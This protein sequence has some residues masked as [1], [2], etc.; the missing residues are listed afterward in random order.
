MNEKYAALKSNVSMLGHLL[1]N[2]IRDAH[3]EELLAK[4]E[5]I[6]KLSK[7]A[8]AGSDEDRNAL[9]EEIKSLPDDQLTPVARA[10]SQFL[11]LTNMAEQYHTIS[12]HCEAHV[13]EPD[14]ISTLFSKLSQSNVSKLDTAQAVRELNIELVLTAHPTEI[15]RRTMINKLVKINECLSKLELG[16]ISFSERDKTERRLEQLIAQ[17][18]HSDVIRQERPT[19]LDEAKWGFAVVENSLWQGIPEFLREFDQ[20]LEGHLGEGLPIDARPVHMSSWMGGDRDG[21]PFVTHKITREVM[22]LSRWKAADLYLKDI[23]ELISELSMVKC[24]DEVRELAGD[25]HEPYRAILKQLRTLLGDT[26]ESLDAQMKGELAPNKVI[27][28]D[29]D[30]LWN[31]LYACYQSLHACGMGIIADGSLLDTLRRVKAFGAHL[32]RLDIR[33]ESTRHSDVLSELT[34]YLGIGDYDQWSEQDKI[35]FLVN[36]L[37]SK[38]PLLPRKWEP[39]PEVQEVID[40]CKVVAEQSKEAL[41]SYVISMARTASDVLAVHLLLQEAGCPFR[42]D[43][44]PLFETLD[45]LNRSKEVM[46]QLFSIDWYRGFIQNHQMVMIGYSD[47]AKDAGV[48]SAGWAQYSAMEA[49]VEVCEKESIELTLFHGRGGT[50]GRGGAPAHAALL[51]QPPKSLKGGL[52]VTEQG[53][54]IRFK[55]GLPEV[56]VNSFNLY[57]SAILEANLLPPPEPKQEWRD[58]ME[59]L[60]EVSC[61][62]YR[63]VVRGEKDFVPYFRAATPELELGKLPLGSRP[64]KRNPN[65]GV[66]S[67]RAIPW[68]FSWSQNR[69]VLPAWLGAG[70]AIQYSIDKGHQALLEEMCRE[71]PFFSTRLGMLEM[72]YTKCNPQMS[73]YYDQRLTDKSLWPLGERLR[74]QLQADIKAVLNVE[75]NDH[76]MERDPWGSE[77][78]RLRNIYVDPLNMLQAELLF[79]TRQQE[80]T[81]PELEEALMVT[82][83]GIAAGMRNTG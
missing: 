62:A 82:I 70:E 29:A 8:R 38:R 52:R 6:R 30:Q 21:N 55:L 36:E 28:T 53:E 40:T 48:M 26:L 44:C 47:S 43:V 65:G 71:W 9:I 56:A 3:G 60:S 72:V 69:L 31:P 39:S 66:E 49:L 20:R 12:R 41:G 5:T 17:A 42:M 79:R 58:L 76:L 33:Q 78:I 80:E 74:N 50:I 25:Q 61:E 32:V 27:L 83:A 35:S 15:A 51:S 4:V 19:P 11:N 18:W 73:E 64:A 68:I 10:F 54:M 22:L 45:D 81:S 34:R 46:E 77:S 23:N 16:D 7:T 1:G 63:N 2:T 13:C 59:V 37:S 14:A 57:A 24:T 67:L 75:N